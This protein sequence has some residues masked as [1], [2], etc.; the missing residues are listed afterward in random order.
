M[1]ASIDDELHNKFSDELPTIRYKES[2]I[3]R[4]ESNG[5]TSDGIHWNAYLTRKERCMHFQ[6]LIDG[7]L[8]AKTDIY[9]CR[10]DVTNLYTEALYLTAGLIWSAIRAK[11]IE[12]YNNDK[13]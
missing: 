7:S 13:Q 4:F 6:L 2:H 1:N 5:M 8:M 11:R 10:E 9:P 12:R 3:D